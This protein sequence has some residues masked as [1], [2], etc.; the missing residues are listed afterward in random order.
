[1]IV[2]FIKKYRLSITLIIGFILLYGGSV[3]FLFDNYIGK[4]ILEVDILNDASILQ[5]ITSILY[6]AYFFLLWHIGRKKESETLLKLSAI[7][8]AIMFIVPLL[9]IFFLIFG[10]ETELGGLIFSY[11]LLATMVPFSGF[12]IKI[13]VVIAVPNTGL[14][15]FILSK[16]SLKKVQ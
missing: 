7:Q 11:I 2:N 14:I 8:S 1:M 15:L 9:C 16:K 5:L 12:G 4:P 3:Y 13:Y 10:L 6:T